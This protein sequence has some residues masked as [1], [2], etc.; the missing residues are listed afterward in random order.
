MK[1]LFFFLFHK[2][3]IRLCDVGSLHHVRSFLRLVGSVVAL[4]GCSCPLAG[5][6][7]DLQRGVSLCPRIAQWFL[8]HWTTREV[9]R[10]SYFLEYYNLVL[11]APV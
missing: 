6:I 9:Q 2:K 3:F 10:R 4:Q 7:S 8:N 11:F 1:G 5:G